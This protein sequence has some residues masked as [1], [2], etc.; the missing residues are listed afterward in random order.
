LKPYVDE[1]SDSDVKEVLSHKTSLEEDIRQRIILIREEISN[2][3]EQI[4]TITFPGKNTKMEFAISHKDLSEIY[5]SFEEYKK[6]IYIQSMEAIENLT[7]QLNKINRIWYLYQ[8]LPTQEWKI[9]TYLYVDKMKYYE[10]VAKLDMPQ[11]TFERKRKSAM[12]SILRSY[13][14]P[15]STLYY[16]MQ[17]QKKCVPLEHEDL[18]F[19]QL[20]LFQQKK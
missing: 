2:V 7:L 14:M 10:V 18:N 3:K 17:C 20:H 4:K 6:N 5:I 11:R 8:T 19:Q 1:I 13:T 9:L 16:Q 15:V 12:K